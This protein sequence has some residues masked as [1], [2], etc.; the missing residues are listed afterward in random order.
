MNRLEANQRLL[1]ILNRIVQNNP[2][3]RFGQ[4]LRNYGFIKEVR[5]GKP[6]LCLEWQNEFYTEPAKV[7][8]RVEQR[9]RDLNEKTDNS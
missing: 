2:D 6:E 3:L 8:A 1:E 9:L 7:L 5:P 4:I